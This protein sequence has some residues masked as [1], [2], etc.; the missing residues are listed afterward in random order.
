MLVAS[1]DKG[2]WR[3]LQNN[4]RDKMQKCNLMRCDFVYHG[5]L[6]GK[7]A[8]KPSLS[9]FCDLEGG[10]TTQKGLVMLWGL[11]NVMLVG[12][13]FTQLD[14]LYKSQMNKAKSRTSRYSVSVSYRDL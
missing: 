1:K 11:E 7:T 3:Y 6:S 5:L 9:P 10:M 12:Q 14:L 13:S 4:E 8:N 2:P